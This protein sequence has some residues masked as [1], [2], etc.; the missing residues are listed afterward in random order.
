MLHSANRARRRVI[1]V[2][3]VLLFVVLCGRSAAYGQ[4]C[5]VADPGCAGLVYCPCSQAGPP[6]VALTPSIANP[7]ICDIVQVFVQARDADVIL[8]HPTSP[9]CCPVGCV[10]YS[11]DDAPIEQ[12]VAAC[13][14]HPDFNVCRF[15]SDGFPCYCWHIW[16][17]TYPDGRVYCSLYGG[18]RGFESEPIFCVDMPGDYVVNVWAYDDRPILAEEFP[19]GYPIVGELDSCRPLQGAAEDPGCICG[20]ERGEAEITITVAPPELSIQFSNDPVNGDSACDEGEHQAYLNCELGF[21]NSS[22]CCDSVQ[23]SIDEPTLGARITPSGRV[24]PGDIDGYVTVRATLVNQHGPY[25]QTQAD[26]RIGSVG[27]GC[28]SGGCGEVG[29][30]VLASEG[31]DV[32]FSLGRDD[33]HKPIGELRFHAQ[34]PSPDLS[35]PSML[36]QNVRHVALSVTRDPNEVISAIQAP[37]ASVVVQVVN[38]YKY[39]VDFRRPGELPPIDPFVR[40]EISNPNESASAD[41]LTVK[42]IIG[43]QTRAIYE[44]HYD[45]VQ[46]E[47]TLLT[48]EGNGDLKRKELSK[49]T[50]LVREYA[51][52]NP[53][54]TIVYR[55]I[56]THESLPGVGNVPVSRVVDPGTPPAQANLVTI[57]TWYSSIQ[58]V[59]RYGRLKSFVNPDGS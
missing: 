56:V 37:E 46:N 36:I 26:L 45:S 51:V 58:G 30:A 59:A 13:K 24:L 43:G 1:T 9:E 10:V 22:Y 39:Y 14:S 25:A 31:P 17:V 40:W 6:I 11:C 55:E 27:G 35:K 18:D 8:A 32:R 19:A 5:Q 41:D 16:T 53:D 7:K 54:D 50:G 42:K 38:D 20:G 4:S 47:W 52:A 23:W 21:C 2:L 3:P 28:A 15:I 49:W 57:Q 29:T 34:T 44:Y 12:N 33:E 48:K